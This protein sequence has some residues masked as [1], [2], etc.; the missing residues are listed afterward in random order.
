MI[1]RCSTYLPFE[2]KPEE[3]AVREENME[4]SGAS[5]RDVAAAVRMTLEPKG[6]DE[7]LV[8]T[9]WEIS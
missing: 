6:M 2:I 7:M 1:L 4:C 3:L 9:R 5:A 8:W